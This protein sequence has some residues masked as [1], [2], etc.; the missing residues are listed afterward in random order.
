MAWSDATSAVLLQ[1]LGTFGQTVVYTPASGTPVTITG[2]FDKEATAI[3]LGGGMPA[4]SSVSPVL[5]IKLS[6]LVAKPA[7]GDRVTV[8]G[9]NYRMIDSEE[10][11]QGGSKLRLQKV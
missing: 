10:D 9:T 7:K 5:L 11:G 3:D 4:V 8:A 6:D 2:V 1:V